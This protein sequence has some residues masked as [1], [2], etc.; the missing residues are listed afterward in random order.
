M[1]Q[2]TVNIIKV[3]KVIKSCNTSAQLKVA[4]R[5]ITALEVANA[6]EYRKQGFDSMDTRFLI[7]KDYDILKDEYEEAYRR[8]ENENF[9]G[10]I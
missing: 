9:F 5:M 7:I 1:Q 6:K 8:I 3:V 10:E 2:A 4:N